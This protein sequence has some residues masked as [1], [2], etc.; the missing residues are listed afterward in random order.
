MNSFKNRLDKF[1][2]DSEVMYNPETNIYDITTSRSSRRAHHVAA[3][4]D[5]DLMPEA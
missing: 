3:D 1:W 4:E 2:N 5:P